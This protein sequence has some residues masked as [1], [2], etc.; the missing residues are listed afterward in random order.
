MEIPNS[1]DTYNT[2]SANTYITGAPSVKFITANSY[3][4][5]SVISVTD[6]NNIAVN[7]LVFA[8]IS[9]VIPAN[10]TVTGIYKGNNTVSLSANL[11]S[12]L[13]TNS[14]G[15]VLLSNSV[16]FVTNILVTANS[17]IKQGISFTNLGES[18]QT[19]STSYAQFIRAQ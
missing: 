5:S 12:D 9:G 18:I 3:S 17:T 13:T 7:Q 14:V 2:V 8:G 1:R 16:S 6:V 11:T 19:S 4:G 10:T 15:N